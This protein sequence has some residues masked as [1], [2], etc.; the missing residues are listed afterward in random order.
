MRAW[1]PAANARRNFSTTHHENINLARTR[2][3][4]LCSIHG[5]AHCTTWPTAAPVAALTA[6]AHRADSPALRATLS[7]AESW[8]ACWPDR[9]R[10]NVCPVPSKPTQPSAKCL[11]RPASQLSRVQMSGTPCKPTQSSAN[12]LPVPRVP[13]H[14]TVTPGVVP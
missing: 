11:A 2:R 14:L 12:V 13:R 5:R 4:A 3:G 10:A 1:L 6:S 9:S 7:C 8:R